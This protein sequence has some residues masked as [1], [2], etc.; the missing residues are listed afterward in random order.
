[1]RKL[2]WALSNGKRLDSLIADL[3]AYITQLHSLT[4]DNFSRKQ[5]LISHYA[6]KYHGSPNF[7]NVATDLGMPGKIINEGV[8]TDGAATES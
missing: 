3:N 5:T 4:K 2:G 1:M 8:L 7:P 6:I